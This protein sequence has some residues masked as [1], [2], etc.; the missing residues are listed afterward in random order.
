MHSLLRCLQI[1]SY[2]QSCLLKCFIVIYYHIFWKFYVQFMYRRG[3]APFKLSVHTITR[4]SKTC[5]IGSQLRHTQVIAIKQLL[6]Y[7]E[8]SS[9]WGALLSDVQVWPL[10]AAVLLNNGHHKEGSKLKLHTNSAYMQIFI[11]EK[12]F[13]PS[14]STKGATL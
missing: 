9:Y 10:R 7:Q 11:I 6:H 4:S 5:S 12:G 14:I 8:T 3:H 2:V 1:T 13:S